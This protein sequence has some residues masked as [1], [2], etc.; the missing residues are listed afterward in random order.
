LAAIVDRQIVDTV[1]PMA[2]GNLV[3]GLLS[4]AALIWARGGS[5]E[6]VDP[7]A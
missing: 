3:Y 1:T 2:V 5:L 7:D 4:L 6:P